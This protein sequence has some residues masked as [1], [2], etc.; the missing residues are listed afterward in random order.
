MDGIS[1]NAGAMA[2]KFESRMRTVADKLRELG[3]RA[4][5]DQM[6]S[7]RQMI[8]NTTPVDTGDLQAAWSPVEQS[9]DLT[10]QVRNDTPYG[11]LL[12]YGGYRRVGPR[13]VQLGGGDL[14]LGFVA[15]GGVYS[16]Q[17]PL[18]FVRKALVASWQPWHLRLRNA[19]SMAWGGLGAQSDILSMGEAASI[20]GIDLGPEAGGFVAPVGMGN[21]RSMLKSLGATQKPS[22]VAG[23]RAKAKHTQRQVQGRRLAAFQKNR[24][25]T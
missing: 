18:G 12:E 21:L 5:H 17:A 25:K 11:A 13:T 22:S 10:Y 6:V 24:K 23:I 1:I 2:A 8:V 15:G 4:T 14:G 20:F 9:G 7:T 16:K 19:L 3:N